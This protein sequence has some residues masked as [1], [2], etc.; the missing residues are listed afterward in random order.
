[1]IR[2]TF[3]SL[4]REVS[5]AVIGQDDA[6]R[7][8]LT[9]M[10]VRG[11]VLLEGVPGTG[12]TLLAKAVA[13]A[14][15]ASFKRIQ[16]TPDLMPSDVTGTNVY[17][18]ACGDF[19]FVPGPIFTDVLLA[20]EINRAVPKT[21]SAL[22]EAMEERQVTVDGERRP[23]SGRFLVIATQNPVEFEGTYPLPEAQLDRFALKAT[24]SYPAPDAEAEVLRRHS[25]GFDPH[26]IGSMGLAK[27]MTADALAALRKE[28]FA[29]RVDAAVIDYVRR[30]AEASRRDDAL[31][32]GVSTR[33]A[34]H[35][36]VTAKVAAASEGRDFVL[37]DD[38]K[39]MAVPVL[40]HRLI[41]QPEA[42]VAGLT[43]AA[44][45]ER[46]LAAVDVPR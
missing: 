33:A 15:D 13:A 29:V 26:D 31:A 4:A 5:K 27:V 6:A 20:D 11:H 1:V 37:P 46:V 30:I 14:T 2:E 8:I 38:V 18:P 42:E 25:E 32:L 44:V 16:F 36:L 7:L 43:A 21:Q 34:A 10:V 23:L 45:V 9:A 41:I 24:V 19:R 12:K 40:A 35:L 3:D 39:A 17:N 22:L 28:A